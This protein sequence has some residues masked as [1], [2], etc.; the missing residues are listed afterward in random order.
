MSLLV[1]LC[2]ESL[3][4]Q[5]LATVRDGHAS[6][7]EMVASGIAGD[8]PSLGPAEHPI[9]LLM[10]PVL[11][12]AALLELFTAV[13]E[14]N[15]APLGVL[16]DRLVQEAATLLVSRF[17]ALERAALPSFWREPTLLHRVLRGTG[18]SLDVPPDVVWFLRDGVNAAVADGV[19]PLQMVVSQPTPHPE[20]AVRLASYLVGLGAA[21]D[22]PDAKDHTAVDLVQPDNPAMLL[23]LVD[24]GARG[25]RRTMS[26]LRL[27]NRLRRDPTAR[28]ELLAAL[29]RLAARNPVLQWSLALEVVLPPP[30]APATLPPDSA[31]MVLC[32][33]LS[34]RSMPTRVL[35]KLCPGG[36]FTR[37]VSLGR[38]A[39]AVAALDGHAVV[40]KWRPEMPGCAAAATE[41]IRRVV[42][43]GLAPHYELVRFPGPVAT[44]VLLTQHITGLGLDTALRTEH[45]ALDT[46]DPRCFSEAVVAAMLVSPEDAT[47][48]NYVVELLDSGLHRLVCVDLEHVFLPPAVATPRVKCVLFCFG[49]MCDPVHPD[50]RADLLALDVMSV[51][52][53]WL[54]KMVTY[55]VQQRALFTSAEAQACAADTREPVI[56]GVPLG[57]GVL[58]DVYSRL[59]RM[60]AALHRNA[61]LTHFELLAMVD[62]PVAARYA[63][64]VLRTLPLDGEGN[65]VSGPE[66]LRRFAEV[67]GK[68]FRHVGNENQTMADCWRL[69]ANIGLTDRTALVPIVFEG[70]DLCPAHM[71]ELDLPA[72]ARQHLRE[73]ACGAA[74]INVLQDPQRLREYLPPVQ[75]TVLDGLALASVPVESQ[76]DMLRVLKDCALHRMSLVGMRALT[77][78]AAVTLGLRSLVQ[79]SLRA[80]PNLLLGSRLTGLLARECPLL[81]ELDVGANSSATVFGP[82][83]GSTIVFPCL[84]SF[85]A[86]GCAALLSVTFGAPL[87]TSMDLHDC[88][89][90]HTLDVAAPMVA[91]LDMRGCPLLAETRSNKSRSTLSLSSVGHVDF[92][93]QM[94]WMDNVLALH[95]AE[96]AVPRMALAQRKKIRSAARSG[97][98]ADLRGTRP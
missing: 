95:P 23:M 32:A 94:W 20:R 42:R 89:R 48:E 16:T 60:Q 26:V 73:D 3:T 14:L 33:T 69:L 19:T 45:A 17:P 74:R 61:H 57:S 72:L 86:D 22:S 79:L 85:K 97:V 54:T 15:A 7:Q 12:D 5:V 66:V 88:V 77:D 1:F 8:A 83:L 36:V 31:L 11:P 56:M 96:A 91:T 87:L 84:R 41:L 40:F 18:E 58:A 53:E 24:A 93:C 29:S 92:S 70:H 50:V 38:R 25:G 43:D 13:Q 49:E 35:A 2:V 67:D 71:L 82:R 47:P 30:P 52:K 46:L 75:E 10:P 39:V 34:E 98:P 37:S 90:L 80:C 21:L 68:C 76:R 78:D 59:A 9:G 65:A 81:T 64:V 62:P 51:L 27:F 55:S 6:L 4:P 44:P 63:N 28:P